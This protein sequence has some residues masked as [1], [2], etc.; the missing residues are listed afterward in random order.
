MPPLFCDPPSF[1]LGPPQKKNWGLPKPSGPASLGQEPGRLWRSI[2]S[3]PQE[4]WELLQR[5]PL[6]WRLA[7]ILCLAFAGVTGG[8][9]RKAAGGSKLNDRRGKP[10]I[11]VLFGCFARMAIPGLPGLIIYQGNPSISPKRT[12]VVTQVLVPMFP[13]TG[14]THF[15]IP[16]F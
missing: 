7:V 10:H 12:P 16:V 3:G 14:A 1:F 6:L 8:E 13:L 9:G 15:G 11:G 4:A 2:A 5:V